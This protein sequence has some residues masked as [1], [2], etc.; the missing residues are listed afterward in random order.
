MVDSL[1]SKRLAGQRI[2]ILINRLVHR[3]LGSPFGQPD[4]LR[5]TTL[6][7]SSIH[8]DGETLFPQKG[9]EHIF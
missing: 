7:L 4:P 9:P 8:F 1:S 3:L 5:Q 2:D 6:L